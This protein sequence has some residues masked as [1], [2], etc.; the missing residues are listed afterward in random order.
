MAL[1]QCPEC[2]KEISDKAGK[3]PNCGYPIEEL[4]SDDR[5]IE[6]TVN[7][8][9]VEEVNVDIPKK[10]NSK[11]IIIIT[12]IVVLAALIGGIAYYTTTADTRN[13]NNAKKLYEEEKYKEALEK[14]TSLGDYEDSKE[15]AEKCSYNLSVDG[16]FMNAL[17][18]GL[19]ARWES[20]DKDE[21]ENLA[22]EIIL[23]NAIK[24][25]LDTLDGF[26][27]NEFDNAELGKKA[28]E[29][30]DTLNA[31]LDTLK[32]YTIDYNKYSIDWQSIYA[33]RIILLKEFVTEYSLTVDKKYQQDI[34]NILKDAS[35]AE[36]QLKMKQ[37][38]SAMTDSFV[39]TPTT[40]EWGYTTYKL[41]MENKTEYTFDYFSADISVLD[42]N[43][44]IIGSGSASQVTNW[45]PG[46]KA[47]VD[48][49]VDLDNVDDL[50]AVTYHVHYQ[51]GNFYE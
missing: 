13:Y 22:E 39:L 40:D 45:Q 25:E 31:S 51:S 7:N 9:I 46:Q 23:E 49:W 41:S 36:E 26:Y 29:Y 3:C 14:F 42:E 37:E 50:Q 1:I 24:K 21:K 15:M 33:E 32:Y 20:I 17:S 10:R 35:G 34:D 48:A 6:E 43:S 8:E 28:K 18:K 4:K 19:A 27:E 2:G 38:I 11:K 47:E 30:V 44:N 12:C 16:Q 5:E